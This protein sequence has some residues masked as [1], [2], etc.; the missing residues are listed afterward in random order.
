[1]RLGPLKIEAE[2]LDAKVTLSV[3]T[4]CGTETFAKPVN[5][6]LNEGFQSVILARH[7]LDLQ[8]KGFIHGRWDELSKNT[9]DIFDLVAVS[10]T[11]YVEDKTYHFEGNVAIIY[12]PENAIV[13]A[14]SLRGRGVWTVKDGDLY[15]TTEQ[16][17]AA[18]IQD[19]GHLFPTFNLDLQTTI[20]DTDRYS[21][22]FLTSRMLVLDLQVGNN[23]LQIRG[24]KR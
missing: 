19:P 23:T 3:D 24:V 2:T 7:E 15:L 17:T 5:D 12:R 20:G 8:T 11:T 10:E 4:P 22:A 6:T 16:M 18:D 9:I 13:F 21:I 1:M 14:A